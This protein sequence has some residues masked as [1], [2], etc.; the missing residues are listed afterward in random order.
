MEH[1]KFQ[2]KTLIVGGGIGG[3]ALALF[4]KN[5]GISSTV[6]EAFPYKDGVGGGLNLAPNGMKVLAALGLAEKTMACGSG[7]LEICFRNERGRVLARFRNGSV[8][9]YRQPA[10]SLTRSALYEVLKD[11]MNA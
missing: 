9:K 7:A 8:E 3:L 5:A 4:L 10:A 11:E 2:G 6:Y 1:P